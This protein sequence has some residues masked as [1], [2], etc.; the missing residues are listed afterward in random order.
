MTNITVAIGTI[1]IWNRPA[2]GF[3]SQ[4]PID[5]LGKS[6]LMDLSALWNSGHSG[7]A[8]DFESIGPRIHR[9][10][11]RG[12]CRNGSGRSLPEEVRRC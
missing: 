6:R 11:N 1:N 7:D 10:P 4:H 5:A 2:V 9:Q 12:P 3:R 8:E